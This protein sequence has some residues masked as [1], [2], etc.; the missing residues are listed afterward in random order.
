MCFDKVLSDVSI[1]III[2]IVIVTHL[3]DVSVLHLL[4]FTSRPVEVLC[5]LLLSD[6][7]E[8]EVV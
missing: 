1:I 7:V 3:P 8:D 4:V 2:A 6:P 5:A